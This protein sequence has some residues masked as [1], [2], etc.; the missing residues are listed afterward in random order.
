M[1]SGLIRASQCGPN[2]HGR[3]ATKP[4]G[5]AETVPD[6]K[7]TGWPLM[8]PAWCDCLLSYAHVMPSQS[9]RG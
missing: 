5:K 4:A 1:R 2:N 7:K 6:D 9:M 8:E 3:T